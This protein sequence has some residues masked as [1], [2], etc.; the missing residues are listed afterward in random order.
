MCKDMYR[1]L[2]NISKIPKCKLC[3]DTGQIF[4][5]ASEEGMKFV[6]CGC[7]IENKNRYSHSDMTKNEEEHKKNL[8]LGLIKS[9]KHKKFIKRGSREEFYDQISSFIEYPILFLP[10]LVKVFEEEKESVD[11]IKRLIG[12]LRLDEFALYIAMDKGIHPITG[13]KWDYYKDRERYEY[14]LDRN[15][16]MIKYLES[17]LKVFETKYKSTYED[18][19][20]KLFVG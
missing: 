20:N 10:E 3:G 14:L 5:M 1:K 19:N 6:S 7:R 17:M 15:F 11:D 18:P 4:V 13:A 9:M 12:I 2:E 16:D 8:T